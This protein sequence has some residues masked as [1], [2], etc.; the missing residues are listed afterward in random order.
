MIEYFEEDPQ[1]SRKYFIDM[2][3]KKRNENM[4]YKIQLVNILPSK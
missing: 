3:Y 2:N 4:K 1:K